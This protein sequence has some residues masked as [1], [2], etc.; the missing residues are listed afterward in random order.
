MCD[1]PSL[2]ALRWP[3]L[4]WEGMMQSKGQESA[5]PHRAGHFPQLALAPH[6]LKRVFPLFMLRSDL[7]PE[8]EIIQ[9]IDFGGIF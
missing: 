3:L 6:P 9:W 8:M 5:A 2:V 1:T 7:T 4:G